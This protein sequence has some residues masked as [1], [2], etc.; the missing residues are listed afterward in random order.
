M[1]ILLYFGKVMFVSALLYGYYWFALR[2]KRFHAYNRFYLGITVIVSLLLPGI[3]MPISF[4]DNNSGGTAKIF[5]IISVG[6]WEQTVVITPHRNWFESLLTLQNIIYASYMLICCIMIFTLA[7]S[8][9]YVLRVS[10]KCNWE[11]I[12]DIKLFHTNEPESPFSFFKNIFWNNGL[13]M[14]SKQGNQIFRHEVY[15]VRNNHSFDILF[16]ETVNCMFW[17]NPFFYFIKKE[18]KVIHEFLADEYAVSG[19]DKYG[20]AELL[21]LQTVSAK[22]INITNTFFHNQIKRR[23]IMMTQLKNKRY[24]YLSRVM[25]LPVLFILFCAFSVKPTNTIH[26]EI[27]QNISGKDDSVFYSVEKYLI[28]HL[29]YPEGSLKENY[30]ATVNVKITVA[31]TGKCKSITPVE[32]IPADTK[33]YEVTVH[34]KSKFGNSASKPPIIET[35]F[36]NNE[37]IPFKESVTK[38]L[39]AFQSDKALNNDVTLFLRVA[40]KIEQDGK[41]MNSAKLSG[42]NSFIQPITVDTIPS[43][44]KFDPKNLSLLMQIPEPSG[45]EKIQVTNKSVMIYGKHKEIL[46]IDRLGYEDQSGSATTIDGNDLKEIS[47]KEN[48]AVFIEKDGSRLIFILDKNYKNQ[49]EMNGKKIIFSK[50]EIEATY[51]GGAEAWR[52]YLLK[53]FRYPDKAIDKEIQGTVVVKYVVSIDGNLSNVVAESGPVEGGLREEA[54]HVIKNSGKWVPA[55]QNGRKVNAY[56]RQPIVFKLQAQ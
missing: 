8:L 29:H 26:S 19:S 30:A 50:V 17:F 38:A 51:P 32:A 31:A 16:L 7:K 47:I 15:H 5:R 35:G 11:R 27:S 13:D 39:S 1:N 40:F 46:Q 23:I 14:E 20:Y 25:A 12:D 21:V 43:V 6:D 24:N 36:N 2:N 28:K 22:Q 49:P 10:K 48:A 4:L 53:T 42:G 52:R 56:K 55:M 54:I 37:F 33:F 3:A 44:A 34:S 18:I 45:V 9:S 41:K